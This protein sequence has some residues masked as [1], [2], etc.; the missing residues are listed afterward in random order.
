MVP[1]LVV[2]C[3]GSAVELRS[4]GDRGVLVHES[5]RSCRSTWLYGM[6]LDR[7]DISCHMIR[8]PNRNCPNAHLI[9]RTCE[10]QRALL[11]FLVIGRSSTNSKEPFF[12]TCLPSSSAMR[13]SFQLSTLSL[14]AAS[15][16]AVYNSEIKVRSN[17][18]LHDG[19]CTHTSLLTSQ[20]IV[21]FRSA[22]MLYTTVT[23]RLCLTHMWQPLT[24][25]M[26]LTGVM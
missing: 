11:S 9:G 18:A 1:L 14:L 5:V 24:C 17:I 4:H 3:W 10:R 15:S 7:Y 8:S 19:H 13:L 16:S 25:P 6:G 21:S 2:A 23:R 22:M 12:S 20:S 26:P